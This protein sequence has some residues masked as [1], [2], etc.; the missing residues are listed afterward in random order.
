MKSM[1]DIENML[2]EAET[3]AS[4]NVFE[5]ITEEA[6]PFWQGCIDRVK[7]GNKLKPY[8]VHRLLREEFGIKISETAIRRHFTDLLEQHDKK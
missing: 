5:R 7:T 8:V 2:K 6:M 1:K 4:S 3:G